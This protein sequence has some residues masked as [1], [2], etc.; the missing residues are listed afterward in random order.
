MRSIF[1]AVAALNGLA[2]VAIGAAAE[3]L[4][5]GD[6]HAVMLAETGVRYGLPHAAVLVAL[7]AIPPPASASAR[8]FLVA[9]GGSLALGATLFCG[10]LYA[11]AA[12]GI[13]SI[14]RLA[15]VGGSLMILGW[16]LLLG[17]AAVS[18]RRS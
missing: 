9:A 8:M 17:F 16:V 14:G 18:P 1:V 5:A 6:P 15:P 12:G 4:W 13:A 3:H 11:L 7:A 2:A 10:S